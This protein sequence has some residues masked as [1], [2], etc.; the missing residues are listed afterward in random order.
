MQ[1]FKPYSTLA[2]GIIIGAVVWPMVK[3]KLPGLPGA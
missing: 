2:V 3:N 1:L